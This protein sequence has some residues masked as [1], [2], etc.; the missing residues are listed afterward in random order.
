MGSVMKPVSRAEF[1]APWS[2]SLKWISGGVSTLLTAIAMGIAARVSDPPNRLWIVAALILVPVVSALFTVL[3]Y[4][5]ADGRLRIRRLLWSDSIPLDALVSVDRDPSLTAGSWRLAGNGGLFSF[6]GWFRSKAL[7]TYRAYVTD[8][9]R[10][11]VLRFHDRR[12]V[13]VSP[14]DPA[15]FVAAVR[16]S[17]RM[18]S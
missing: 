6:S 4:Q 17:R 18:G 9:D 10:A 3:E 14:A 1:D 7:G 13:V 15:A 5:V 2:T 12:A 8:F 16:T 11:V